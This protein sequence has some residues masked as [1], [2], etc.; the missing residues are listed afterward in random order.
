MRTRQSGYISYSFKRNIS[1][2]ARCSLFVCICMH[3]AEVLCVFSM[4][5]TGHLL[6]L[7]VIKLLVRCSNQIFLLS[8]TKKF[9]KK[10]RMHWKLSNCVCFASNIIFRYNKTESFFDFLYLSA[11]LLARAAFLG[12]SA[13]NVSLLT[14]K[15]K[16][17][18]MFIL[19]YKLD[20]ISC[21]CGH[22]TNALFIFPWAVFSSFTGLFIKTCCS[23][24][25]EIQSVVS[26]HHCFVFFDVPSIN[27]THWF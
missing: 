5:Q 15:G 1:T 23:N 25:N 6:V 7:F 11:N 10:M 4:E 8:R 9:Y 3:R 22:A 2:V 16:T 21:T 18:S 17:M 13:K 20:T 19:R 12:L 26:Q 14:C 27:S 24:S